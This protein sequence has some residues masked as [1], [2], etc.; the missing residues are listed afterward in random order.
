MKAEDKN[1]WFLDGIA[2]MKL[3]HKTKPD[4]NKT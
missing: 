1:K 4:L 2:P 3:K